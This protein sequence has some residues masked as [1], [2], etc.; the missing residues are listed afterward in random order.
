MK[1]FL[2]FTALSLICT[3][4]Y[5][6]VNDKQTP[7]KNKNDTTTKT[8][9]YVPVPSSN[10]KSVMVLDPM[11]RATD[12]VNAL[13]QLQKER[14]SKKCYIKT[15]KGKTINNI[16]EITPMSKGT[17]LLIKTATIQGQD[18]NIVFTEDISDFGLQ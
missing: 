16:S 7:Q 15:S 5:A 4:S 10:S 14:F 6:Q 18:I 17:I 1:S 13:A 8:N 2:F 11:N 12:I 9:N 3:S